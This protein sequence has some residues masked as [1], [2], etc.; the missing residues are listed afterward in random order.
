[1][2]NFH[3][4]RIDFAGIKEKVMEVFEGHRELLTVFN[5]Y[6][7]NEFKINLPQEDELRKSKKPFQ[8]EVAMKF[9]NNMKMGLQD[10]YHIYISFLEVLNS[11]R[12]GKISVFQVADLLS[13]HQDLLMEFTTLFPDY[14]IAH[15]QHKHSEKETIDAHAEQSQHVG[16]PDPDNEGSEQHRSTHESY[17]R[18]LENAVLNHFPTDMHDR[19]V[20]LCKTV[21]GQLRNPDKYPQFLKCIKH[22]QTENINL[23]QL[24]SLVHDLLQEHPNLVKEF[25]EVTN[26]IDKGKGKRSATSSRIT[27]DQGKRKR[28]RVSKEVK[29]KVKSLHELD[30]SNCESCTP[31]F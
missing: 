7:P 6:L 25:G 22:Y 16:Q 8:Y 27:L 13:D 19:V 23:Q 2:R 26:H 12:M 30:L 14:H 18:S 31:K 17:V 29:N 20:H 21:K 24:K 9:V 5:T 15:N 11:Y 10:G 1:M 28:S 4:S 3:K